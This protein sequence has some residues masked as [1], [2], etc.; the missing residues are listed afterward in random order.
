MVHDVSRVHL[1][2]SRIFLGPSLRR[3]GGCL[4]EGRLSRE[5]PVSPA[6]F[7]RI[8]L[9]RCGSSGWLLPPLV[10]DM[11]AVHWEV[12][13]S[14]LSGGTGLSEATFATVRL[15]PFEFCDCEWGDRDAGTSGTLT[16]QTSVCGS[17]KARHYLTWNRTASMSWH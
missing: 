5:T 12:R 13:A 8:A 17:R 15:E 10:A 9:K 2:V 16:C 14:L 6:C 11:R 4:P 7:N 3:P 1:S